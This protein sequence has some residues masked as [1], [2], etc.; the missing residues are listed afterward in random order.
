MES[1][2]VFHVA[3][4]ALFVEKPWHRNGSERPFRRRDVSEND[5]QSV[6]LRS[7]YPLSGRP[8]LVYF[9]S[10]EACGSQ[11]RAE[12]DNDEKGRLVTTSY[13][14]SYSPN[15][16]LTGFSY[17]RLILDSSRVSIEYRV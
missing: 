7:R 11:R 17:Y 3:V 12:V 4:D 2:E 14:R 10:L 6:L 1:H 16:D 13:Y 9:V 15:Y 8:G 5:G